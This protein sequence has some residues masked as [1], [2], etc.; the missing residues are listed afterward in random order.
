MVGDYAITRRVLIGQL[1]SL[2]ASQLASQAV[3][4]QSDDDPLHQLHTAHPRLILLDSDLDRVRGLVR[5]NPL[6]HRIYLD[7]EKESERL[8]TVAPTEYKLVGPRL[9]AQSRRV[10]DRVATL[11]L[12]YRITQRE[13]YQR[14]AMAELRAAAGFRDWNPAVFAD[15]AEM[16]H[17]FAIGYDWLYN[18]LSPEERALIRDA[19]VT[20]AFDQAI[21][22]YQR[23]T[24]WT[25]TAFNANIICNAGMGLGALAIAGDASVVGDA[26]G[27]KAAPDKS[28]DDKCSAV[29]RYAFDSIPHGLATY[30]V[31][32]AWPEGPTYWES[33]TMYA[34]AF[35]AALQTALGNDYG[36]S[37][38]HGVDRAGRFRI[39][40]T[41][42]TGKVFNFADAVEDAGLAPEMFWL[43]KRFGNPVFA[44][45]E[46]KLLEHSTH[47]DAYDL[48]WFDRDAKS[49]QQPPAWA[50]DAI[51]RGVDI[52]CFRS[53]WDDPNAL[54][55]A[56][57]GGDNKGPHADLDLGT[58]VLDAGGVR[59]AS[60]LGLDDYDLPGYLGR[61][62]WSYYRTRTEAHNTLLVD[63]QN[64]DLRAEAR[65]TRQE[66]APDFS[67]V[68]ID[69]SRAN[70]GKVKQWQRRF[71][72]AQRQAV[73]IADSVRC[74]QPVEI[75]WG[76]MTDA[77]ITVTGQTA[78]LR[79]N[80]WNLAAEIRTP[81]HAVF[82]VAPVRSSPPQAANPNFRKLVVRLGD[83][84]TELDLTIVLTPYRD[85][86]TKPKITA[87]FP[88]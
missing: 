23:E 48:V 15:T 44:W 79:K 51:F 56:V 47:P 53:A 76:M 4:A 36:L 41:G 21:P 18:V 69:L 83:K 57:K 13:P 10:L 5:D 1:A 68:Q 19:I 6:A 35:F 17:A 40:M 54:Y 30:G 22:I 71:A 87:Q 2:L 24:G 70:P 27:D 12:M 16:T 65:I 46:Q 43:A 75:I 84:V 78:L 42:P 63:D 28:I 50:L 58:F 72:M 66:F 34:C 9:R 59:W 74:D 61:Q 81:R 77:E 20:K 85:G 64:Q 60:D 80:G 25:R 49:P 55:L 8:L 14:R 3:W 7:L 88:V 26:P 73:L 39:F 29:L 32:G 62:R 82:D 11:S 52:S 37:A 86:Q 67:W 31:E 45:S 33:V 38:S